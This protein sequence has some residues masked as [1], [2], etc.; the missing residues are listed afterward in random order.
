[1]S[2]A[3]ASDHHHDKQSLNRTLQPMSGATASNR[4]HDKQ[5]LNRTLQPMSGA[6]ASDHH[7]DKQ[8]LNRT[9]QPMSGATASDRHHDN[10]SLNWTLH[11]TTNV[12]SDHHHDNQSLEHFT[13]QTMSEAQTRI[14]QQTKQFVLHENITKMI[15]YLSDTTKQ[16]SQTVVLEVRPIMS[17]LHKDQR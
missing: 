9:L 12:R 7:H 6:T 10:Q 1:M 11:W 13:A 14:T 4:H 5:S 2:E 15:F 8:S 17:Y 16:N 3:T